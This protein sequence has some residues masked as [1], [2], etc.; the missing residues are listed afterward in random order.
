M[1]LEKVEKVDGTLHYVIEHDGQEYIVESCTRLSP[2]E[3]LKRLE[4]GEYEV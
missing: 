2:D 3:L 1:T 4:E